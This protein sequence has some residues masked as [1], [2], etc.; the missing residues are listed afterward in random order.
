MLP[1]GI[2]KKSKLLL[3]KPLTRSSRPL[4]YAEALAII[5]DHRRSGR[6]V[7]V[8]SASP[9]EIVRPLCRYLGID[10]IIATKSEIDEEG[11]YTGA[12]ELY[13]YGPGKSEAMKDLAEA[14]RHRFGSE[15]R[16]LRFDHR[17]AHARSSR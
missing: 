9:E 8:V 10:D 14:E 4:V 13:A 16:L 1:V 11:K 6:K 2:G 17:P 7:V 12:I 5:D 15:L 3:R